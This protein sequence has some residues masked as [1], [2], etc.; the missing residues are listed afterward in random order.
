VPGVLT[1]YRDAEY[2]FTCDARCSDPAAADV[3]CGGFF[4]NT[5]YVFKGKEGERGPSITGTWGMEG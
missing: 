3:A 5:V 2:N 4:A 1:K